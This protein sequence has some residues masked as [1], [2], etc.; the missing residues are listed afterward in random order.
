M[1]H[2]AV[3][4]T[5]AAMGISGTIDKMASFYLVL[6]SEILLGF[7]SSVVF[8]KAQ[9][10]RRQA[11]G[12]SEM[13]TANNG[14]MESMGSAWTTAWLAQHKPAQ[15]TVKFPFASIP[16]HPQLLQPLMP[17]GSIF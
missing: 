11:P 8:S 17:S 4:P 9:K 15:S 10:D 6:C 14:V 7:L 16:Q 13:G 12:R 2:C 3:L 1:L 5:K